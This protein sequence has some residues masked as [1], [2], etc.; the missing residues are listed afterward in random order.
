MSTPAATVTITL[1]DSNGMETSR[2][3]E[4]RSA[5]VTDAQAYA[6][7]DLLQAI[8]Q[9]EVVG[10]Q[11]TRN[12]AGYTPI[13]AEANSAVAETA[14]VRV[15]M[16]AGGFKT[17]SLPALKSAL[18]SGSNVIGTD[19]DLLAFLAQFDDGGGVAAT[20]GLFYVSDGEELSEVA[21]EAG[22]VTGKIN[23]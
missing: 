17:F 20:A 6:L 1:R 11:V 22:Q 10:V 4:A 2:R 18:K 5:A 12:V 21:L 14:S 8:T 15:E 3:Y 19:T 7:A 9:L 16:A 23:R 13:A